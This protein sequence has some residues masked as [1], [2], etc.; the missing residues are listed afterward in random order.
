MAKNTIT[1]EQIV[2]EVCKRQQK[3]KGY[4][5][6]RGTARDI[7]NHLSDLMAEN[8]HLNYDLEV[9]T[10]MRESGLQRIPNRIPD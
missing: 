7:V 9:A 8:W 3:Q 1:L 4:A 6:Y 5:V 10:V 2:D